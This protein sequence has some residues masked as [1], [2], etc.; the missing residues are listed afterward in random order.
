MPNSVLCRR[1]TASTIRRISS[2]CCAPIDSGIRI[3]SA[4]KKSTSLRRKGRENRMKT[5]CLSMTEE[6]LLLTRRYFLQLAGTGL[7]ATSP[8]LAAAQLRVELPPGSGKLEY[9]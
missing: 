6:H 4:G 7:A 5:G 8:L 2:A 9:L 1:T 3:L